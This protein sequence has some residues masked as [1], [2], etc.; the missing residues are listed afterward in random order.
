MVGAV[1]TAPPPNFLGEL[2]AAL[3]RGFVNDPPAFV[4]HAA[5]MLKRGLHILCEIFRAWIVLACASALARAGHC[6]T[7]PRVARLAK[8]AEI[9]RRVVPF[10]AV[11]VIYD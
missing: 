4:M 9:F 8:P 6:Q 11:A 5:P 1:G 7:K 3:W 10:V 2:A